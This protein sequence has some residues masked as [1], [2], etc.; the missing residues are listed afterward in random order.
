[1]HPRAVLER[2]SDEADFDEVDVVER[3]AVGRLAGAAGAVAEA[4]AV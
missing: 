1:M 3:A 2:V 4:E